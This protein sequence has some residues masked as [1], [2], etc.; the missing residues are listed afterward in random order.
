MIIRKVE[1]SKSTIWRKLRRRK[2][3]MTI[4]TI[5]MIYFTFYHGSGVAIN[6]VDDIITARQL[7]DG[8]FDD[9]NGGIVGRVMKKNKCTHTPYVLIGDIVVTMPPVPPISERID[10]PSYV[11]LCQEFINRSE[12]GV[13][14]ISGDEER[15]G[16]NGGGIR[17]VFSVVEDESICTDW[18]APHYNILSIYASSLIAAVG[19]GLGLRYKHNCRRHIPKM[20]NDPS[21]HYD[22]TSVQ[23][24]LPENLIASTDAEK[25]T[26]ELVTELCNR[27]IWD[28]ENVDQLEYKSGVTHHCILMPDEDSARSVIDKNMELPM[29]SILPS[30]IDRLRHMADDWIVTT[31][32][33]DGEGESGVIIAVDE[34]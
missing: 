11:Q 9:D 3:A 17:G 20:H 22:Y 7:Q 21:R 25:V 8:A 23:A 19:K 33:P 6:D 18:E 5:T 4:L 15:N 27:C 28:Y 2:K 10:P 24:L 13:N 29:V 14:E 30:L 31:G 1:D 34:K 12:A 26:P 32:H 16:N